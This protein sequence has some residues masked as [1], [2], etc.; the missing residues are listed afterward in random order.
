VHAAADHG[1]KS[2]P[3]EQTQGEAK[4]TARAAPL[5]VDADEKGEEGAVA[6][7]ST[8]VQCVRLEHVSALSK[9]IKYYVLTLRGRRITAQSGVVGREKSEKEN[10]KDMPDEEFALQSF[11]R[12][13]DDKLSKGYAVVTVEQKKTR[14]E[15]AV[16]VADPP[17]LTR[18][19]SR[20]AAAVGAGAG[21]HDRVAKA[22]NSNAEAK[23][24]ARAKGV[25]GEWTIGDQETEMNIGADGENEDEDENRTPRGVGAGASSDDENENDFEDVD[26]NT[27]ATV[28]NVNIEVVLADPETLRSCVLR[29]EGQRFTQI[30]GK[31]GLPQRST[32]ATLR[33]ADQ[34]Q[35]LLYAVMRGRLKKGFQVQEEKQTK[36]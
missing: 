27:S 31:I 35:L 7:S 28:P 20:L 15:S 5:A 23:A 32:N 29:Q 25:G 18:S 26:V 22:K 11:N 10:S 3:Q 17:R 36:A 4:R 19:R 13:V 6:S 34:A 8:S 14:V 16:A 24:E 12:L 33:S 9:L 2:P 1:E 21:S 30:R